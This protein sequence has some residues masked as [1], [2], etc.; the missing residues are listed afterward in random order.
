MPYVFPIHK[1]YAR[2]SAWRKPHAGAF[3]ALRFNRWIR[4]SLTTLER[5]TQCD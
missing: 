4:R 1:R 5:I 3:A 2:I